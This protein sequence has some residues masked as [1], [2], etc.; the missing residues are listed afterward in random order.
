VSARATFQALGTT[1]IVAVAEAAALEEAHAILAGELA[2]VDNTCSRF[3]TDSELAHVNRS[4]GAPVDVSPRLRD[5]LHAALA[6]AAETDGLID[7]TLGAELRAIGYDR[8]FALVQSR[9]GWQV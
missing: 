3:R 1:A 7:P 9:G 2:H 6:A 4:R 5:E 8:T